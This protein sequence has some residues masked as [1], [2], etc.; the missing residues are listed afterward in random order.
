MHLPATLMIVVST[1]LAV[2][3]ADV[4]CAINAH[5]STDKGAL[6]TCLSNYRTDNWDGEYC[7]GVGW[8]KGSMFYDNPQDCYDACVG[9]ISGA[10]DSGATDVQ[11]D[12]YE[13]LADCWM[14]FH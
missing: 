3:F 13:G 14:G 11:C 9:C 6:H 7:G 1:M 8:F 2:S 12:D 4:D 10:I 5:G